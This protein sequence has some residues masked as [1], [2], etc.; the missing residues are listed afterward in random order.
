MR[1]LLHIRGRI[2]GLYLILNSLLMTKEGQRVFLLK[3]FEGCSPPLSSYVVRMVLDRDR[4]EQ[5][6]LLGAVGIFMI[7]GPWLLHPHIGGGNP[8]PGITKTD[9]NGLCQINE[10][11]KQAYFFRPEILSDG[12]T[13]SRNL[14]KR[15]ALKF[16]Q[17]DRVPKCEGITKSVTRYRIKGCLSNFSVKL[18]QYL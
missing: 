11:Q 8:S 3:M 12:W 6:G 18:L 14:G 13:S 1:H 5:D 2:S 16:L 9:L 4:E 15:V 7:G 17:V 10:S